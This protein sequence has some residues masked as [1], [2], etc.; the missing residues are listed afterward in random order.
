MLNTKFSSKQCHIPRLLVYS[1][2]I[3]PSKHRICHWYLYPNQQH[4]M[5][6]WYD[7]TIDNDL[8]SL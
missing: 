4:N 1:D 8:R 3:Y 2:E 5:S 6:I 7:T